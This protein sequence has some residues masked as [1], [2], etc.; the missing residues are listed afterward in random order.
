MN[1]NEINEIVINEFN[2]VMKEIIENLDDDTVYNL[3][4]IVKLPLFMITIKNLINK[5]IP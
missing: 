5:M 3:H 4:D 1:R 2:I